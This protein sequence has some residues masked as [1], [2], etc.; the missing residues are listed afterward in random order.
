MRTGLGGIKTEPMMLEIC[1]DT[2]TDATAM[3]ELA[4]VMAHS[5]VVTRWKGVYHGHSSP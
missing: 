3:C 1:D 5:G 4:V 2:W